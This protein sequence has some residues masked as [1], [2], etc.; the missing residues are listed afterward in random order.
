MRKIIVLFL[1]LTTFAIISC[2]KETKEAVTPAIEK[3]SIFASFQKSSNL[4]ST[5]APEEV[6]NG[7][8][9]LCPKGIKG[10]MKAINSGGL[11]IDG[12]WEMTL[13]ESD[14]TFPGNQYQW[15]YV[16]DQITPSFDPC[17]VYRITFKKYIDQG[18][19]F[20]TVTFYARVYGIPG[21][22]GDED[23]YNFN[24]RME[25]RQLWNNTLQ[26]AETV[27]FLYFKYADTSFSPE[28]ANC[29]LNAMT[30]DPNKDYAQVFNLKKW[31]YSKDNYYYFSFVPKGD[32]L[33]YKAQFK[34]N[35]VY[36]GWNNPDYNNALSEFTKFNNYITFFVQ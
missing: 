3:V 12:K 22:T 4:K 2:K 8:T 30:S 14:F 34:I 11:P 27:V 20:Y 7:D 10:L 19:D 18:G 32:A 13:T 35:D 17:G 36:H 28:Q 24:F 1:A 31:M 29:Q 5:A 9:I 26:K 33:Y 23:L 21:K 16:G 25:S 6:K 15:N